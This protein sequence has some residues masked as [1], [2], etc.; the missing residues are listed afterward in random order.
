MSSSPTAA[1]EPREDHGRDGPV[2][3]LIAYTIWGF[4]PICF[5]LVMLFFYMDRG[6]RIQY[7]RLEH[8]PI[9]G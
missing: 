5:K 7:R 1:D 6:R 3:V 8:Q 4:M 9:E 2:A